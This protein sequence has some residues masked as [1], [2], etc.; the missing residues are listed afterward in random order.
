MLGFSHLDG[1]V[2]R[3]PPRESR[4]GI[5][6]RFLQRAFPGSCLTSDLK[7]GAIVATLPGAWRDRISARTS[8]FHVSVFSVTIDSIYSF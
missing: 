6:A 7:T 8:W 2:V 5:E 4:N 1:L 3:R